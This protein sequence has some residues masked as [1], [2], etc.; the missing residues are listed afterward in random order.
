MLELNLVYQS[1]AFLL[2]TSSTSLVQSICNRGCDLALGSYYTRYQTDIVSIARYINTDVNNIL[3]YN[4]NTV[5]SQDSLRLFVRISVPFSCECINGEY[6]G[7]VFNYNLTFGDTYPKIADM[8]YANLTTED[9]IQ[10]IN[11]YDPSQLPDMSS[12]N[13]TVNCSCGDG[14]VSKDYGL[15]ITYPLRPG[16]TLESISSEANLSSELIQSYNPDVKFS[17]GSGLIYI[18][19]RG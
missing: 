7:H 6:L 10:M 15:F 2:L 5:L 1:V 18:P 3:K 14:S 12:I 19:G 11:I 16:E 13:V 8:W 9:W 17:Q 4:P